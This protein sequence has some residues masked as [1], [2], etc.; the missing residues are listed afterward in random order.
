M[1]SCCSWRSVE[2]RAYAAASFNRVR[3]AWVESAPFALL[4]ADSPEGG[5][6]FV[7]S[8]GMAWD[9]VVRDRGLARLGVLRPN[10]VLAPLL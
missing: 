8:G 5:L 3:A 1:L 2:T 9:I 4:R 6:G 10:L 7:V